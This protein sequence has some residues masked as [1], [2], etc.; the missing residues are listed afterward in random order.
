MFFQYDFSIKAKIIQDN[1]YPF[2]VQYVQNLLTE[3][4]YCDKIELQII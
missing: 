4:N 2:L 3:E 1:F